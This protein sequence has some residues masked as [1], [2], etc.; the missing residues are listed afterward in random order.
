MAGTNRTYISQFFNRD[1]G[2]SFFDYVNGLRVEYAKSLLLT[3]SD[4]I[5]MVAE[6]SG[7]NSTGHISS[8]VLPIVWLHS[9]SVSQG[10]DQ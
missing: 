6:R 8:G 1:N 3:S 4:S 5:A 7:F 10:V 2:T 9:G